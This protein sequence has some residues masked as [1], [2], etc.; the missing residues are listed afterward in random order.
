MPGFVK[1]Y[2]TSHTRMQIGEN[3]NLFDWTYV[4]NHAHA[5]ILAADALLKAYKSP[6]LPPENKRVDGKVFYTIN[7]EPRLHF[8]DSPRAVYAALSE[9]VGDGKFE[10]KPEVMPQ[11]QALLLAHVMTWVCW[12]LGKKSPL[13]TVSVYHCCRTAYFNNEKAKERL[14]YRVRVSIKEA[15]KKSAMVCCFL[16]SMDSG[17]LTPE[18]VVCRAGSLRKAVRWEEEYLSIAKLVAAALYRM[19]GISVRGTCILYRSSSIP[20]QRPIC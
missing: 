4:G 7:D 16:Y 20:I 2:N 9:A 18:L 13:T 6:T 5:H 12:L 19:L 8:W 17:V 3:S 1:F 10:V 14:G 15:V 11:W